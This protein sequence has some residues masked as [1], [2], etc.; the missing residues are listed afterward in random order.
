MYKYTIDD[1]IT[2]PLASSVGVTIEF[3]AGKRWLF[4][5]TP[6]LLSSV[7]DFASGTHARL[8]LGEKHMIVASEISKQVIDSVSEQLALSGKLEARSVPLSGGA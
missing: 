7:G 1:E 5:D 8:H 6:E 2:L 4:F 3:P